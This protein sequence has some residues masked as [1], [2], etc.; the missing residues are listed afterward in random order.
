R[1]EA[2]RDPD[3]PVDAPTGE[4]WAVREVAVDVGDAE[5]TPLDR[6]AGDLREDPHT[7]EEEVRTAPGLAQHVEEGA[8]I[9]PSP[10][11]IAEE[12]PL[13]TQDRQR[14]EGQ[15]VRTL[16]PADRGRLDGFAGLAEEREQ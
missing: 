8:E 4:G 9:A 12:P 2:V 1:R 16:D 10:L 14:Q 7:T 3:Q 6:H 15:V 5:L 11:A 13:R